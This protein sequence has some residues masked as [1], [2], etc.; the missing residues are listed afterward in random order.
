MWGVAKLWYVFHAFAARLGGN[1]YS[2]RRALAKSSSLIAVCYAVSDLSWFLIAACI[3]ATLYIFLLIDERRQELYPN[4]PIQARV[5]RAPPAPPSQWQLLAFGV[6]ANVV[7]TLGVAILLV[8][9]LPI[10]LLVAV[11]VAVEDRQ[12]SSN[13][14]SES[15]YAHSS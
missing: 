3:F 7:A 11:A 8:L 2:R 4:P 14:H 10:I 1:V 13:A 12:W 15:S 5:P 9:L 6:A